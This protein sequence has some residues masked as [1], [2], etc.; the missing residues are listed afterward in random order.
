MTIDEIEK[1][2][3]LSIV[4][5]NSQFNPIKNEVLAL[6][7]DTK[8]QLTQ[9]R[10]NNSELKEQITEWCVAHFNGFKRPS[11][12]ERVVTEAEEEETEENKE[13]S[14]KK[15]ALQRKIKEKQKEY[16]SLKE[17]KKEKENGFDPFDEFNLELDD[18]IDD[19]EEDK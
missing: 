6:M 8:A 14:A 11:K 5:E 17:E 4:K 1:E 19:G 13:I 3:I 18:Y 9:R 2:V 10:P 7:N 15:E 16:E 12:I